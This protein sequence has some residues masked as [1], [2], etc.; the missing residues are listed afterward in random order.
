MSIRRI[1]FS[2]PTVLG[3]ER[4]YL[5]QA[6]GSGSLASGGP[7]SLRC[8]RLLE[9]LTGAH[10]AILTHSCTGALELAA[11][12]L[13]IGPG[14]E[15]ILPSFTFVSTATAVVL[16]GATPVFV[17]IDPVSLNLDPQAVEHAITA[18][19]RAVV[20]VHYGGVGTGVVEIAALCARHGL[21]LIEDTAHGIGASFDGRPLGSFGQ[22]AALSFHA[23]KN[24]TSGEGGALLI[25]DPDLI[26]R[27]EILSE[28]GTDRSRFDRGET[29]RY[30][31]QDVGSSFR[32]GAITAAFLLGQLEAVE[33]V[34]RRRSK[35][36]RHY[37]DALAP[38]EADG[39]LQRPHVSAAAQ[40]NAHIYYVLLPDQQC[41]QRLID[42]LAGDGIQALTHYEPLHDS[43]AGRRYGRSAG[44][45]ANTVS[46]ARRLLR[47]PLHLGLC[48][49][50]L[51]AVVAAVGRSLDARP[52]FSQAV[53]V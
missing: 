45:M 25:N 6:L 12:L 10:R 15:V 48:T 52:P 17:D 34:N 16:R 33:T 18:A 46:V 22:V 24:I 27:A 3:C 31:W 47:L 29:S 32:A 7:F 11:L 41:R 2:E 53:A 14:D 36:W 49:E 20:M 13:S 8:E 9:G 19:T 28:K 35:H 26:P 21:I 42:D 4:D 50:D 44:S 23:S 43:P 39:Q 30:V 40:G 38:F 5:V 51:D 1:A 37:H